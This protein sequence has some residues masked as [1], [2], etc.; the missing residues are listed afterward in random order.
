MVLPQN[1]SLNYNSSYTKCISFKVLKEM[2]AK[3]LEIK[4]FW[5][6]DALIE[7]SL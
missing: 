7:D 4:M 2:Q 3:G 5:F 6:Y 1:L